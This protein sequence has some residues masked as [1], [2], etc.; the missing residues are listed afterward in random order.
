MDEWR[1][2]CLGWSGQ[3]VQHPRS[4]ATQPIR[5]KLRGTA[6]HQSDRG[7]DPAS[8]RARP[9]GNPRIADRLQAPCPKEPAAD[10]EAEAPQRG[11]RCWCRCGAART[12]G[13]YCDECFLAE[14]PTNPALVIDTVYDERG[15]PAARILGRDASAAQNQSCML[16]AA[17]LG[18]PD[19]ERGMWSRHAFDQACASAGAN[20]PDQYTEDY[21]LVASPSWDEIFARH[22]LVPPFRLKAIRA[23]RRR[24]PAARLPAAGGH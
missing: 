13:K 15:D 24:A 11:C 22:D 16:F 19:I 23:A 12:R 7:I 6:A 5:C 2:S 3:R 9:P 17:L 14:R 20:N 8:K 21:T 1:S 10:G 4:N 18:I